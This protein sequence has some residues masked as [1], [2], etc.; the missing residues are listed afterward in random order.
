[1][2]AETHLA[3]PARASRRVPLRAMVF[4][5]GSVSGKTLR[6][7]R[8]AM[9]AV[10]ALVGVMIVAG[11]EVMSTTYGSL[12]TRAELGAMARDIPA[13]MRGFYGDPV[14]TDTLGGF[15]SWHY[16]AYFGLI[17]GL[18]SILA[19]SATL[20]GE[21][22]R[23][24]LEFAVAT[25]LPAG[26]GGREGRRPRRRGGA[27][28]GGRRPR[29]LAHGHGLCDRSSGSDPGRHGGCLRHRVDNPRAHRGVRSVRPRAVRG[30]R[31]LGG[32]RRG[33]HGRRV[34]DVWV[35]NGRAPLR[36]AVRCD[37]V[38]VAGRA[39][40]ARRSGGVARRGVHR[41]RMLRPAGR[42][43]GGVRTSRHRRHDRPADAGAAARAHRRGRPDPPLVRG[44]AHRRLLV[45][46]GPRHSTASS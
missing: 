15:I 27:R 40:P 14:N 41:D 19:L 32:D 20:A 43:S 28:D 23:G 34:R 37:V 3:P 39:H 9:L 11:G 13:M 33:A 31:R 17:G 26:A 5:L 1:M 12:A 8:G 21:A 38:A 2:T 4:G 18:W 45:G 42:G 16:G 10:L 6:D 29:R 7:S 24:S 25:K 46:R 22:R 30:P 44:P 36:R 35:P